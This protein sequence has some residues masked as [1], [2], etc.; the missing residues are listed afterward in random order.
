VARHLPGKETVSKPRTQQEL[1]MFFL[2]TD[3]TCWDEEQFLE[4][5]QWMEDEAAQREYQS[6]LD[7]INELHKDDK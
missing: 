3:G 5:R 4:M 1:E 7:T 6:W 2:P